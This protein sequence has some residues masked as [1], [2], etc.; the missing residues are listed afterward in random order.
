MSK[1]LPPN[2]QLAAAD[3]WPLVGEKVSDPSRMEEPWYVSIGGLVAQSKEWSLEDLQKLPQEERVIDIDCVTRW[4]KPG[5]VFGGFSLKTL[6]DVCVVLPEAKFVSFIARSA[7]G[8]NTSL[9]LNEVLALDVFV[10]LS[11]E[12]QPLVPEHG[13]PIRTVVPKKYFYKSLKWLEKIELLAED[14]LGTWE[15]DSG[16]H[17]NADPWKEERYIIPNIQKHEQLKLIGQRNFEGQDLLGIDAKDRN[18]EDLNAKMA[19]LRD[20]HFEN[21]NLE[22]ACFD[23][24]NLSNA[25]LDHANLKNASFLD[26]DCEGADFRGADLTGADFTDASLFGATFTPENPEDKNQQSAIIDTSTKFTDEKLKDLTPVQYDYV[27]QQLGV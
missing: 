18:L 15:K 14:S 4:S 26:A 6:L 7:Q 20:S 10:A 22:N 25:H 2:Q 17:N 11:Y 21:T 12:G 27:K 13:G 5:A 19:L 8:H 9:P 24:A 16:Y 23:R 1:P 3:K